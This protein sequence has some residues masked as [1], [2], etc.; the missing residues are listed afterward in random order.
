MIGALKQRA[1]QWSGGCGEQAGGSG[2]TGLPSGR[3]SFRDGFRERVRPGAVGDAGRGGQEPP[4]GRLRSAEGRH[5]VGIHDAAP[6]QPSQG[7]L[8]FSCLSA[9]H[10]RLTLHSQCFQHFLK[11]WG[12]RVVISLPVTTPLEC[13]SHGAFRPCHSR[14]LQAAAPCW[15][16]ALFNASRCQA[17]ALCSC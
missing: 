9:F 17:Q 10:S 13:V 11:Q 3:V 4:A 2:A 12:E 5:R 8:H 1:Y 14:A 15:H 16:P 6:W 7:M